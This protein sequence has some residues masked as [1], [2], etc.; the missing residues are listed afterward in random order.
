VK[1]LVGFIVNPLAGIGGP[2]GFKGSDGAYAVRALMM[3]A[4]PVS[5]RRAEAFIDAFSSEARRRGLH[6]EIL[7]PPGLMGYDEA[8][9]AAG[10]LD[11]TEA[12]CTPRGVWPTTAHDTR[13]CARYMESAGVD[14]LV[15]VGGDGTARDVYESV[16][17]RLPVLGVPAGVKV[18]SAV[19]AVNPVEA[20]RVVADY[21]EGRRGLEERPVV[22]IDEDEYRRGRL[23]LRV[24]GYMLVPGG[25]G[26]VPSSKA[27][28]SY[29]GVDEIA[30]FFAEEL[31]EPCTL[32]VLGP[33]ETVARIA[34][35]LGAPKT[36]LGVDVYHDGR[37]VARDVDEETLYRIVREHRERGGRT[38]IVVSPVGGQGF[39][40]GRGNQQISPRIVK[41]VGRDNIVV[42]AS[43]DK[44]RSLDSLR[45]DTGDREVDEMLRG[46]IRVLTGYGRWRLARVV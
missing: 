23:V 30:E 9:K 25:E 27:H 43:E 11:V 17:K 32:L 38:L 2:L 1:R 39:I 40:L 14:I 24:Y 21:L 46:Y 5:P 34:E 26:V 7:A 18:Y 19:F 12:P 16:D 15:F 3:G 35:R 22:D 10:V 20:A 42:V 8:S 36:L 31:V 37:I 33:G 4:K 45:V 44:L 13:R 28:A 29:S 41:L 6:V